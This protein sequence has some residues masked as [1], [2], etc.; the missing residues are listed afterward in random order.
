ME[1]AMALMPVRR[2]EKKIQP[3]REAADVQPID[4]QP[5]ELEVVTGHSKQF[6]EAN[7][8]QTTLQHLKSDCVV[9]VFSKDNELT[10]S[11]VSFIESVFEAAV[12]VFPHECITTPEIRVSQVS[13]ISKCNFSGENNNYF[14]RRKR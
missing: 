9:P 5:V 10:I 3:Y 13:S 2:V 7:T 11:H 8:K 6:I 12:R 14:F 4:I 1:A